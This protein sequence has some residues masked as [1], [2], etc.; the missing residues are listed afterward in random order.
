MAA[1]ELDMDKI[2]IKKWVS[3]ICWVAGPGNRI[4][5]SGGGGDGGLLEGEEKSEGFR[6]QAEGERG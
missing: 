3:G 4:G 1:S 2:V 6:E 5:G